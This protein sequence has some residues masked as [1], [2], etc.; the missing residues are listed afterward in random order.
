M[1]YVPNTEKQAMDMLESIGKKSIEDLFEGI[2]ESVRLKKPLDL[3]AGK[4]EFEV[5]E[6]L[7]G[8]AEKNKLYNSCFLG[9]GAYKHYIPS[10]VRHL[11]SRSEFVTAYT[12]YQA[13]LSQGILKAIFEY[14]T[15]ICELTGMDVSNAGVYDGAHAAAEAT[16]MFRERKRQKTLIS[17][18]AKP[19]VIET[20]KTYCETAGQAFVL[21]S[22]KD[23]KTDLEALATELDDTV[24]S[25]Y[26]E[27]PNFYGLIEDVKALGDLAHG[28]GAKLIVGS[29]PIALGLLKTPA[30]L[31][32][33]AAVGEA[34]PL[35]LPLSFGG[36]YLG[37]MAVPTSHMRKLPGRIAGKTADSQG[38]DAYVLTLQA[39]EQHIRREK[40]SSS[41][42]T[43]TALCALTA[44]IY[45]AAM[46]KE[47]L[48]EVAEQCYSKAH[49]AAPKISSVKGYTLTHKGEFFN[50][51]LTACPEDP[52]VLLERLGQKG[53]LAGLPLK[54]NDQNHILWCVTE[55]NSKAEIDTLVELLKEGV[56]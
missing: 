24:A 50:E 27:Y 5:L 26:M 2:P 20:V 22:A 46:G 14:Q 36:P 13:E 52:K 35:G 48:R 47:G 15:T 1:A 4:S 44:T 38:R 54:I 49:Y 43:N 34:Q 16:I 31:G 32:A 29:Y 25:V 11:A 45:C 3:E 30:E 53:I 18:A 55:V 17:A 28:A 9:A 8:L 51:F 56:K 33:D 10:V 42:C 37:Y 41:V 6:K 23:G 40:A 12:P 19:M 7:E 39:R 21:I